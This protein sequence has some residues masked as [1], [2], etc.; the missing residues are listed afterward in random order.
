MHVRNLLVGLVVVAIGVSALLVSLYTPKISGQQSA[1]AATAVLPSQPEV[2]ATSAVV[3]DIR[4]REVLYAK[5]PYTQLPLASITKV[6][7]ALV[8]REVL[9]RNA[10]ITISAQSLSREGESGFSVGEEW[11]MQ[12]L[13]DLT[14]VTSSNDG[15]EALKEAAAPRIVERYPAAPRDNAF[16]W[17]MNQIAQEIG[18]SQTFFLDATGLDISESQ[19]SSYGSALDVARLFSY[20]LSAQPDTLAS[21]AKDGFLVNSTNG[22]EHTANNTNK[23]LGEIPGLIAGKTGYTDLA[24]GN[25]AIVFDAGLQRPIIV[26]VLHSTQEGR[27]EDVERLVSYARERIGTQESL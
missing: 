11:D 20:A 26:V 5:N 22:S 3:Y 25:L 27:F 16:V 24:G 14:L 9:A 12:A 10:I 4:E 1:Q 19:A 17:R 13:T 23:A 2:L 6:M 15:A 7:T 8:A 21:T 18:M